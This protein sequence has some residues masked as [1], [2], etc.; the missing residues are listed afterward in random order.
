[1]RDVLNSRIKWEVNRV[2]GNLMRSY[3]RIDLVKWVFLARPAGD[4]KGGPRAG[5]GAWIECIRSESSTDMWLFPHYWSVGRSAL[6]YFRLL[7]GLLH[8]SNDVVTT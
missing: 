4:R 5:A 6:I 1:M 3:R 7:N 8:L 2:K